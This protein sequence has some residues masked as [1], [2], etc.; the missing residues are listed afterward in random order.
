MKSTFRFVPL[1]VAVLAVSAALLMAADASSRSS[2]VAPSL[3]VHEWGTFTSVAGEDGS[4]NLEWRYPGLRRATFRGLRTRLRISEISKSRLQWHRAH[5][6]A[7]DVLL[8]FARV[9][10]ACEGRIPPSA[11]HRVVSPGG[12]SNSPSAKPMAGRCDAPVGIQLRTAIDM[13]MRSLTGGTRVAKRHQSSAGHGYPLC[14]SRAAPNRY[15]AARETDS[16]PISVGDQ[17][18]K[19]LFYRGVGRFQVPLS[20]PRLRRRENR[21]REPRPRNLLPA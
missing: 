20:A 1:M 14:P 13:S 2:P 18:E 15:Y 9:G 17:H 7:S 6:D 4:A 8:Q 12:V 11:H 3:T 21:C 19:F 5:G 10:C 16:A